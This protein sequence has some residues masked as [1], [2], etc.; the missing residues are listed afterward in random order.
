MPK[1]SCEESGSDRVMGSSL[2]NCFSTQSAMCGWLQAVKGLITSQRWS[3][4]PCVR[5]ISAAY[6]AAGHNALRGSGPGQKLAFNDAV[7]HVGCPDHRPC[8]K[9]VSD[10]TGSAL[11]A[12]GP[13]QP[14]HRAY[15]HDLVP[16][17]FALI[18]QVRWV[19][20]NTRPWPTWPKPC[21]RSCWPVLSRQLS[22]GA[23]RAAWQATGDVWSRGSSR[24]G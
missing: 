9:H 1:G 14:S 21:V 5:P 11:R 3:E 2:Q 17:R 6:G 13:F 8:W 22:S 23:A 15:W 4:Q 24:S 7:A 10:M 20:Y 18:G 19:P 16:R 12:V